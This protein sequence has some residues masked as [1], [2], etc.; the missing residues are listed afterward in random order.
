LLKGFL[1][2]PPSNEDLRSNEDFAKDVQ[3]YNRF[4]VVVGGACFQR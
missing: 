3:N 1:E 4:L 2:A